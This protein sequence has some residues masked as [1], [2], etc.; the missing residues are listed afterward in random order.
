MKGEQSAA[1]AYAVAVLAA[2]AGLSVTALS[3]GPLGGPLFMFEFVAVVGA[4]TYGGFWPGLLT[5]VLS[6]IGFSAL[7]VP[8]FELHAAF[9]LATFVLVSL[10][11]AWLAAK[12]RDAW[13]NAKEARAKAEAAEAEARMIGAHQE[14]L[15]AVVGHDLRNSLNVIALAVRYLQEPGGDPERRAKSLARI[16]KSVGRMQA[17]IRDLLDYAR[18]R[19]GSGL[20]IRPQPLRLGDA[21]RAAVEE[22]R[23][24]QPDRTILVDVVGDDSA[25]LDSARVEQ[26]VCNLLTNALKHATPDTPVKVNVAGD[27]VGLRVEITNEGPSIPQHLAP[28]L[29]DAFQS[30]DTH[31]VGL[32]LFIVREIVRAHGGD[33]SFRS[34]EQ[35]TTFTATFPRDLVQAV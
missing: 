31:G 33:V 19:H 27:G 16:A 29:F 11:F 1:T 34:G 21:C 28:T 30:G 25:V 18:A 17:L 3:V 9:R 15:L 24:A 35:G 22:V 4:T 13:S 26:V 10:I 23:S 12:K 8:S 14:R 20:P 5:M 7:F 6:G 2:L 32:G